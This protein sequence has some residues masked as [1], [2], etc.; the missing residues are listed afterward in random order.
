LF[1]SII[2]EQMTWSKIWNDLRMPAD[3]T[4]RWLT[5]LQTI[6]QN[7]SPASPI[8]FHWCSNP[9]QW[10]SDPGQFGIQDADN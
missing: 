8:R 7:W 4:P 1:R 3:S 6:L 2:H 9:G 10:C 5:A